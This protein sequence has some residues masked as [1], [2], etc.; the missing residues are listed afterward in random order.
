MGQQQKQDEEFGSP[1]FAASAA[2]VVR[3]QDMGELESETAEDD[4]SE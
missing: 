3:E 4:S 2:A 1:N